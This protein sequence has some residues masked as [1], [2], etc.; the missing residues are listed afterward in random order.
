MFAC[1]T[2]HVRILPAPASS[3]VSFSRR[4]FLQ[5]SAV[6]AF[7]ALAVPSWARAPRRSIAG[8]PLRIP[9]VFS[10]AELVAA[11]QPMQIWPGGTSEIWTLG[12]SFP[13]P[14]I[15]MR[16]GQ[17]LDLVL[18]NQLPVPTIVHWHG[19]VIPS[20]MD[21][22]P[23]S[24]IEPG[25]EFHYRFTVDQ[26]AGTYWYHPHPHGDTG[27]QV[28]RGMAG[29]FIV[30]DDESLSLGLPSGEFEVPLILADRMPGPNGE[31]P[32]Q[33]TQ[34]QKLNGVFG[35]EVLVNG[36]P[37]AYFEVEQGLYRF[38][39]L[40]G[41]NAKIYKLAFEDG[42]SFDLIGNEGGLLDRPYSVEFIHLAPGERADVLVDFSGRSIG[43]SVMLESLRFNSASAPDS[44]GGEI[45]VT[46]FDVTRARSGNRTIPQTL[47]TLEHLDPTAAVRT[48]TFELETEPL[49]PDP[50]HING[51][52]FEMMR[53]DERVN[54]GELEIWEL[55]NLHIMPHPIHIHG[56]QFQVVS[57][58]GVTGN[59]PRDTGWK[60]GVIVWSRE[61]VEVVI[62]FPRHTGVFLLHCHNL[63]HEDDGM[64]LNYE[65]VDP[66]LVSSDD[67]AETIRVIPVADG[68]LRL[69]LRLERP[70]RVM[71][72]IYSLDGSLLGRTNGGWRMAGDH[73]IPIE[74]DTGSAGVRA[75]VVEIGGR[76]FTELVP[77]L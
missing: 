21:G 6:S 52:I 59:P 49:N 50:H 70:E 5:L 16:R 30:E 76:R 61:T 47:A 8:N 43:S 23:M 64:M 60:D 34:Q 67:T 3:A 25:E 24:A 75:V 65:I 45:A 72:S 54:A 1:G 41:S 18:R 19:L 68:T 77:R 48:R 26:R 39:L 35:S 46:R 32:Y 36:T 40:N 38:R 69:A 66:S 7:A 56:V 13:A 2:I 57:R 15:R 27:R 10:G 14:T 53:I 17:E 71:I 42:A 11:V 9:P 58:N 20:E 74:G 44:Q 55:K 29:M 63:E 22:H 31:L 51:R 12:G 62:R 73:I 33:P 28:Y 37:G 4:S